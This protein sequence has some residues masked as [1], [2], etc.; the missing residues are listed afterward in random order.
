MGRRVAGELKLRAPACL[1]RRM[2]GIFI[3]LS[4]P[5]NLTGDIAVDLGIG[6]GRPSNLSS[7]MEG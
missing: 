4:P 1:V 7:K 3:Y 2:F 6:R 5:C